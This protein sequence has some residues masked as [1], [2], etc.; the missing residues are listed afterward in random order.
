MLLEALETIL[1]MALELEMVFFREIVVMII[2]MEMM[3]K[4]PLFFAAHLVSTK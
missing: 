4:I 1:S 2:L 3:V